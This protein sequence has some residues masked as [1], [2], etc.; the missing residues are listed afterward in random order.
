MI[1]YPPEMLNRK[2]GMWT[3]ISREIQRRGK[4]PYAQVQCSCGKVFWK[5]LDNL[6]SMKSTMCRP[7]ATTQRHVKAGHL[8]VT[9]KAV[10]MLQRRATA[11]MQRCSNPKDKGW[12]HYGGRGIQC[13]FTSVKEL[14]SYL[15]ELAPAE[16]WKGLTIDRIN[17]NGHYEKGNLRRAT[18]SEN[19]LNRRKS[20]R[21][22]MTS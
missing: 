11:V 19:N 5:A 9:S 6:K 7:C 14:V 18:Y 17:N 3:V 15:I 16:Q 4:H 10:E 12:R 2:F 22:S 20:I 8:H 21:K 1:S 13:M